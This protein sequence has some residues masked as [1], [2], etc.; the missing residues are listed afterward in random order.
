MSDPDLARAVGQLGRTPD[1]IARLT[2][3]L[4]RHAQTWKPSPGEFSILENVYHLRDIESAG[5]LVRIR[6]L[7]AEEGPR[8]PDLDGAR[9]ARERSYNTA[10]LR[11]A[12]DGFHSAR[13]ATLQ[14]L[15]GIGGSELGRAGHLETVGPITLRQLL[16]RM[17]EH[18]IGHL[19][20]IESL[21]KR[22]PGP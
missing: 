11:S 19:E 8:L 5:H 9:L 6:R 14:A 22:L 18:D 13:L 15:Q 17:A 10:D 7:I 20:E 1:E 12:V 21:R 4:D 3:G 2:H 16:V